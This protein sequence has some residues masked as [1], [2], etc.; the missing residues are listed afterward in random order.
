MQGGDIYAPQ[1][2]Y[3]WLYS[4]FFHIEINGH[5]IQFMSLIRWDVDG[6]Y[7]IVSYFNSIQMS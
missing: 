7:Q 2:K 1:I 4:I 6:K 3:G 5:Q